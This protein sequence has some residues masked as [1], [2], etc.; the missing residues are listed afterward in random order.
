MS[1]IFLMI[2]TDLSALIQ[3]LTHYSY[4]IG[5]LLVTALQQKM[6]VAFSSKL[7]VIVQLF[8][9]NSAVQNAKALK[10]AN[11]HIHMLT[12]IT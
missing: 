7:A 10:E 1:A 11:F 3:L 5:V 12:Q 9:E 8:N 4:I 6:E 2:K